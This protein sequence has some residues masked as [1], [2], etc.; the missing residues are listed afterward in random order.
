MTVLQPR[1]PWNYGQDNTVNGFALIV[2]NDYKGLT[3]FDKLQGPRI[4]GENMCNTMKILKF[5]THWAHNASF[6][7]TCALLRRTRN[8]QYRPNYKRLVFVFSGHGGANRILYTQDGKPIK[9]EED[10]LETFYP[11]NLPRLGAMAKKFFIEAC[12]GG[13]A[14]NLQRWS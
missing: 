5:E 2:T 14:D 3:K 4:D 8:C 13:R 7:V 6:A 12:R 1:I 10:I 11:E 9:I